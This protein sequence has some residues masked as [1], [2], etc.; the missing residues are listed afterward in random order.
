MDNIENNENSIIEQEE[1]QKTEAQEEDKIPSDLEICD[2]RSGIL[3][4]LI[5]LFVFLV[6][7]A[8]TTPV[9]LQ[10]THKPAIYL[11]SE[12]PT[13]VSIKLDKTIKY[14]ITIPKYKKGWRVQTEPNGIIKDLQPKYTKCSKLPDTFGFEYAKKACKENQYPYIYWDGIELTKPIPK[15][16]YGF[17][18]KKE[19]I[20]AFLTAKA[21]ELKFN[22]AEKKEFV[23]YWSKTALDKNWKKYKIYFLQNEEVQTLYPLY[24]EPTPDSLNRVQII[25]SKAKRKDNPSSQTLKPI[26]RKGLT[27][28]EWGGSILK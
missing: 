19:H 1:N 2:Y 6:C 21:D 28:V 15:K 27:L 13:Q 4:K 9:L 24:V 25:I 20:E 7:V 12:K 23:R 14:D 11:Y 26:E 5:L 17:I 8:L 16:D 22:E 10:N 3:L 18:V